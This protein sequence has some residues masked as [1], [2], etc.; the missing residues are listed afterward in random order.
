[1]NSLSN[2]KHRKLRKHCE[3]KKRKLKDELPSLLCSLRTYKHYKQ[4]T[5]WNA[6]RCYSLRITYLIFETLQ[7][8][9]PTASLIFTTV[10]VFIK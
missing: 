5:R 8:L 2:G 7:T 1:M 4:L 10:K 9:F 3:C 6:N